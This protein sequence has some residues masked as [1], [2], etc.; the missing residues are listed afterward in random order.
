MA[1]TTRHQRA[2]LLRVG[3]PQDEGNALALSGDLS[4]DGVRELLAREFTPRQRTAWIRATVYALSLVGSDVRLVDGEVRLHGRPHVQF[5]RG[6]A[7]ARLK[8]LELQICRES[9]GDTAY[10]PS[11]P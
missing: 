10:W 1:S 6:S 7:P 4:D 9:Y 8:T 3:A 2:L 11:P 5:T